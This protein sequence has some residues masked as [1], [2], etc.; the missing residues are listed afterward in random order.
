MSDKSKISWTDASWQPVVGCTKC[1]PGC[2][3][4]YAEKMAYRLA[5][6]GLKKYQKVISTDGGVWNH[7]IHCDAAALDKPLHW[8]KPRKIFVCS[9]SDLFHKDIPGDFLARVLNVMGGC[10]QHTFQVLTKRAER[11]KYIMEEYYKVTRLVP[12]EYRTE[13]PYKNLKL[14]VSIS[15]QAEADEKLPILAKIPAAY[16]FVSFEPLLESAYIPYGCR[17]TFNGIIIGAESR[18]GAAGRK[19]NLE[20]VRRLAGYKD[21]GYKV[22]IKQ[23]H[24][25]GKL[26]KDPRK[27][28]KDL[29]IQENI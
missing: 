12:E 10:E 3:N 16:K 6:M 5:C 27:F 2:L 26:V 8:R 22:H 23:L 24:I 19:C 1:S 13:I 17:A 15:T 21:C 11:M 9:M 18:G 7:K 29:Q 28:P 14:G 4:C 20:W 25:D